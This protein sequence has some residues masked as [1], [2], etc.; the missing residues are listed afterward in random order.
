MNGS[1][2]IVLVPSPSAPTGFPALDISGN[3]VT[4]RGLV[5]AGFELGAAVSTFS[6]GGVG[7]KFEGN[8]FGTTPDGTAAIVGGICWHPHRRTGR[9]DHRR[10]DTISSQLDFPADT[11]ADFVASLVTFTRYFSEGA[12]G[13]FWETS[14]AL[15]NGSG[16]ATTADVAFLLPDG[17]RESITVPLTGPGHAVIDPATVPALGGSAVFS[18]VITAPVPLVASR[19][20]RWGGADGLGAHAEQALSEPRTVWYFGEGVTGCADLFYLLVNP[21]TTAADVEV[22][23]ARR[24]PATPIVLRYTVDPN[25]RKTIHVNAEDGLAAA[26]VS[27]RIVVTNGQPIIAER[28][29]YMSCFGSTWRGGHDAAASPAP[30]RS[31]YFAEGATG[32][33]F[34]LYLLIA[35]FEP[36]KAELEVEYLLDDSSRIVKPYVVEPGSRLTI[37]VANE[38]PQLANAAISSIV[39]STNDVPVIAERAQWWPD[40]GWYE[41]HV[42]AGVVESGVEWQLAGAQVGG[43]HGVH[44]YLLIANTGSTAGTAQVRAVFA[45]GTTA[46][47]AQPIALGMHSRTTISLAEAFPQA[48]GSRS[49]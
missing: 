3:N 33:F 41:G 22:T 21:G 14:I 31:W 13:P 27:G 45:D 2:Q 12:I 36:T 42:S 19:T 25:S 49:A 8:Y 4:V 28:S 37:D 9:R 39:R 38:A 15:L 40:G 17:R 5:F 18:T 46:Q 20:M 10:D 43:P 48:T 6:G 34:D 7:V 11:T 1:L 29:M 32:S 26:E 24:A 16:T 35:N 47:L 30:A 23:Y 44:G